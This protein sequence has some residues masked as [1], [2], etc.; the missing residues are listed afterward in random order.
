MHVCYLCWYYM[1]MTWVM[2]VMIDILVSVHNRWGQFIHCS[3]C[4]TQQAVW[5][6]IS[7]SMG[8]NWSEEPRNKSFLGTNWLLVQH[9]QHPVTWEK[10]K[11]SRTKLVGFLSIW[12][13]TWWKGCALWTTCFASITII[14]AG[15]Y[16]LL[17]TLSPSYGHHEWHKCI[18]QQVI[19][20]VEL[21]IRYLHHYWIHKL[22]IGLCNLLKFLPSNYIR[23]C[24]EY[25][26]VK[27]DLWSYNW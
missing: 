3:E 14:L 24:W 16:T 19:C 1:L 6:V 21:V 13:N 17:A 11:L 26:N 25:E 5:S 9:P 2:L 22:N 15:A 27:W 20:K 10:S 4:H 12:N 7:I 18:M 23:T 8:L